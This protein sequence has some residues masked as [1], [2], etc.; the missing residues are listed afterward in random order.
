MYAYQR[1]MW[2]SERVGEGWTG[3]KRMIENEGD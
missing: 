1:V 2:D 3:R